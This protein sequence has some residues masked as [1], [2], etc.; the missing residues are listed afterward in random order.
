[1]APAAIRKKTTDKP[2]KRKHCAIGLILFAAFNRK[3]NDWIVAEATKR[4]AVNSANKEDWRN[5]ARG[6]DHAKREHDLA[7]SEYVD[8]V[9]G[10]AGC[11]GYVKRRAS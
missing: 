8:H 11:H 2:L 5:V 4:T 1:M 6:V 3:T 10:C 7:F 9:I